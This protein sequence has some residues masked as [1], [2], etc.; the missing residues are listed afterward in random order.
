[1]SGNNLPEEDCGVLLTPK[2]NIM[3][4]FTI[5]TSC[6]DNAGGGGGVGVDEC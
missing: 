2:D 6:S 4:S 1:M 3:S 5:F